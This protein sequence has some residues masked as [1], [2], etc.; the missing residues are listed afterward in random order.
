MDFGDIKNVHLN[1]DRRTGYVKVD[2]GN[3]GYALLEY[4]EYEEAKKAISEMDG[5]D[6]QGRK[7]KCDFAF[8][9]GSSTSEQ[10]RK[11]YVDVH[12]VVVKIDDS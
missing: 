2:M 4:R 7:L 11:S 12:V 9:R 1:L 8:V 5:R 6:V 10:V 3:E